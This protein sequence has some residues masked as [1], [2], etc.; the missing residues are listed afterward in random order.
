[1]PADEARIIPFLNPELPPLEAIDRYFELSRKAGWYSNEG[2][3]YRLFVTR[4]QEFLGDG[5]SVVPLAN[6]TLG[7][8]LA[9][10]ALAGRP[11]GLRTEVVVPSFT[12]PATAAAIEWAGF[13]PVFADVDLDSWHLDPEALEQALGERGERVAAVLACSTFG[14]PPTAHVTEAWE[15]LAGKAGVP[16]LVD[17]AAGFGARDASGQRLGYQ[18]DAEA[19]SFHATKPFAVGE[20]GAVVTRDTEFAERV[21]LLTNFGLGPERVVTETG[22]N[23]KLDEWHAAACL[24]ALDRIDDVITARRRHAELMRDPLEQLGFVF[25][26]G[27]EHSTWQFVPVLAPDTVARAATLARAAAD[28]LE[29]RTYFDP[30]L[31]RMS[32]FASCARIGSL[33]VTES[34]AARVLSLPLANNF[35]AEARQRVVATLEAAVV[36]V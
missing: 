30:P 7:L 4:A 14:V 34:L 3:C 18:G 2:P 16:L 32:A 35:P 5:V 25:Q 27:S 22:L 36:A 8:L 9:L 10:H 15:R 21:R 6:C 31:H 12:F 17:S 1:M 13:A 33:S 26:Y 24:A 19:F 20:G 28:G 11:D 29:V 23:A